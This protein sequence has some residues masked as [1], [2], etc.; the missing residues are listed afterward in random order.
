MVNIYNNT[1]TRTHTQALVGVK[2]LLGS[3]ENVPL[4]NARKSRVTRTGCVLPLSQTT[5]EN[6]FIAVIFRPSSGDARFIDNR[7]TGVQ[8]RNNV[9]QLKK[10]QQRLALRLFTS[11][12][13]KRTL[14]HPTPEIHLLQP[15]QTLL[16]PV[17][18]QPNL[19][20]LVFRSMQWCCDKLLC[21]FSVQGTAA[22]RVR[23]M[24]SAA[25]PTSAV[26]S[27]SVHKCHVDPG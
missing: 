25:C 16:Q 14:P 5:D 1:H 22:E 19:D 21:Y 20:P 4:V 2:C 17:P 23:W 15:G 3:R 27:R 26:L 10:N 13:T 11:T 18:P 9:G 7:T 12:Q 6:D 24:T 8:L